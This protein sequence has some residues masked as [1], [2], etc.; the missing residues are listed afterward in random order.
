MSLDRVTVARM[1]ELLQ[2]DYGQ[3][4][5]ARVIDNRYVL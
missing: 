3:R 4:E 1:A 2:D 5:I